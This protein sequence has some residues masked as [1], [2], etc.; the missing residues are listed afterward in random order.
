[1]DI[2]SSLLELPRDAVLVR[3]LLERIASIGRETRDE[4]R[5]AARASWAFFCSENSHFCPD[6]F[7]EAQ[8]HSSSIL[9]YYCL[10]HMLARERRDEEV[11]SDVEETY[12]ELMENSEICTMLDVSRFSENLINWS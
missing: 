1:M 3:D 4:E 8:M 9:A 11:E 12:L 10:L 7:A 6:T 5:F 2:V